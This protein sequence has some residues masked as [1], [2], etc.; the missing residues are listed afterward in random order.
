[1]GPGAGVTQSGCHAPERRLGRVKDQP[2]GQGGTLSRAAP[3][4][5]AKTS[6]T[7]VGYSR[8]NS[9]DGGSTPPISTGSER[10]AA[11]TAA[12]RRVCRRPQPAD[13]ARQARRGPATPPPLR[14]AGSTRNSEHHR[15]RPLVLPALHPLAASRPCPPGTT[16]PCV[17]RPATPSYRGAGKTTAQECPQ[18][19]TAERTHPGT[20]MVQYCQLGQTLIP[21]PDDPRGY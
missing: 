1:M 18:S 6:T 11:T 9:L 14:P 13:A 4:A 8:R 2:A 19:T 10:T 15:G 5:R 20:D 21:G 17:L 12:V 16:G 7:L 3:V